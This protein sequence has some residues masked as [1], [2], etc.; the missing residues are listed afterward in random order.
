[1]KPR[2]VLGFIYAI[3]I[4]LLLLT[5]L[6]PDKGVRIGN[7][8]I[9]FAKWDDI[10]S[11]PCKSV[12]DST[13]KQQMLIASKLEKQATQSDSIFEKTEKDS[14]SIT[15]KNDT[16]ENEI[17]EEELKKN[18]YPIQFPDEKSRKLF[19]SFFNKARYH[20]HK[21]IRILY[22]GDSQI[23][24]DRITSYL[25]FRLQ[26][27]FGGYG[28]G[29]IPPVNFV[30]FFSI[31]QSHDASWQRFSVMNIGKDSLSH[32]K[33]G[34][35]ASLSKFLPTENN[36][37]TLTFE[38]A[39]RSYSN[40]HHWDKFTLFYG[41]YSGNAVIQLFANNK[42]IDFA[43]L[44]S[45]ELNVYSTILPKRTHKLDIK[46]KGED[47]PD[48]YAVSF[49]AHKGGIAVDNIAIRGCSGIFF[50]KIN[51]Q[52][53]KTFFKHIHVGLIVLEFGGNVLPYLNDERKCERYTHYFETQLKFFRKNFPK[54]PILVIGP[55]DMSTKIEGEMQTYPLLEKVVEGLKQ[56]AFNQGYGFWNMYDAMGGKNS[57]V[58]WV[59]AGLASTDYTHFT[60]KGALIIAN[61]LTNAILEEYKFYKHKK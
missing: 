41:N 44:K 43:S 40:T 17:K 37:H 55:A 28:P 29:L 36:E 35:L 24:G 19:W 33:Y 11:L 27:M 50:T 23:E 61:M 13:I 20:G 31:K 5:F 51:T 30:P 56:A 14:V 26:K 38:V 57:M 45:G 15:E 4:I 58:A 3:F 59:D 12:I 52:H 48:F 47:S 42:L 53:Y 10:T 22:Y 2:D 60:S 39:K 21:T 34:I 49:D 9:K 6:F 46:I 32:K 7:Q 1:M 25:R 16:I 54:V 18:L 8:T